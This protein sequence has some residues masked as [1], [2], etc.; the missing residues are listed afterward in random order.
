MMNKR[1]QGILEYLP[2]I[3]AAVVVLAFVI[4]G[5]STNWAVFSTFFPQDNVK[6]VITQC[7]AACVGSDNYGFC[8][9]QRPLMASDLPLDTAGKPQTQVVNTCYFFSTFANKGNKPYG[10][11]S[12][13]S[14]TCSS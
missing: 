13:P 12:C 4:W 8:T 9:L 3:I 10:I 14:I 11:A 1:G 5:F 6:N 7:Q 2:V